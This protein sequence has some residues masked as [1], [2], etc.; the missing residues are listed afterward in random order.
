MI[1]SSQITSKLINR[2]IFCNSNSFSNFYTNSATY[3]SI[4]NNKIDGLSNSKID[5]NDIN[6]SIRLNK[7]LS[8][9]VNQRNLMTQ[10]CVLHSVK[11]SISSTLLSNSS[12][13]TQD[14]GANGTENFENED[15][16]DVDERLPRLWHYLTQPQPIPS[17]AVNNNNVSDKSVKNVNSNEN[18]SFRV[19]SFN[20]LAQSLV[21]DK[22][23][24]N[25][26]RTMSWDHRR[27]EILREISQSNS[28]ILC[29][30][31]I[32]E[33]DYLEF[34]KPKTEA[35]GYNSVYKR[36]LQNKLDG[37]LT[38]FRSQRYKLLLK[39]ELEFSSQRPD[40][41][42][43]QV[44]IVLALVDLHSTTSVGANTSGPVVKGNMENDCVENPETS[45]NTSTKK[46][47]EISE[48][49]VLLVTNTHLIFNKSRG[50]I[51]LYQLCNL[52]KG[53]QKTIEFL[54]SSQTENKFGEPLEQ[55]F[56][57]GVKSTIST[58]Q[59]YKD[60]VSSRLRNTE[61]SVVICG[62]FNITPQSLIYNLIFKG[63][64]PLRNSNPRLLSGQYLMF[65][66]TYLTASTGHNESG[67]TLGNAKHYISDIYSTSN[68]SK[69]V[70]SP[71]TDNTVTGSADKT[72]ESSSVEN[73]VT[74]KDSNAVETP[75]TNTSGNM[76]DIVENTNNWYEE[77]G[78]DE[79]FK[80]RPDHVSLEAE[81]DFVNL[82]QSKSADLSQEFANKLS[83]NSLNTS[84]VNS[85]SNDNIGSGDMVYC[86]LKLSSAY[87]MGDS[88]NS[89]P[90]FTAFHGWQRGCVD[91][92]CYDPSLVQLE[93]I[94]E[95]PHYSHVRRNGDLPHKK[96]PASDHFSLISQFKRIK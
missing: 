6:Y 55:T 39:N 61:P 12:L 11:S 80:V 20:A 63:F 73:S 38:L 40:F 89:E 54:N 35:L 25:D 2:R 19:M 44:A 58:T 67:E 30:Q 86:P 14:E 87:A 62:D 26:K 31:E 96:W 32:D 76:D 27:E 1:L 65:D 9:V 81:E 69:N 45:D 52:V 36:K 48:S 18:L 72:V 59:D 75:K 29:L 88:F 34:F 10:A 46:V 43:P 82:I 3:R 15:K 94:Y 51:K 74:S 77:I 84:S 22:Y 37:I 17:T 5:N 41:N 64:A 28:D 16:D 66:N 56:S 68:T 53:I 93:A 13:N 90:A 57:L 47:N 70:D 33:R 79:E 23:V 24:Q 60:W 91:Y 85:V 92:I 78:I 7:M 71:N 42:K 83:L 49:D 8:K 95:M 50:D 4:S 21:D